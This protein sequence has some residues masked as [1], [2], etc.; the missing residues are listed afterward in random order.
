[1][2]GFLCL[3]SVLDRL[4]LGTDFEHLMNTGKQEARFPGPK[5][6]IYW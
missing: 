5:C 6:F 1:M 2:R 4:S 3:E